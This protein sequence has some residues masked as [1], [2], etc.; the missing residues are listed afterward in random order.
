[1]PSSGYVAD[2]LKWPRQA[3]ANLYLFNKII[4]HNNRKAGKRQ[5]CGSTGAQEPLMSAAND[6]DETG[7]RNGPEEARRYLAAVLGKM[8]QPLVVLDG[9][10]RVEMANSAF[11]RTFGV[12]AS[13]TA[14]ARHQF[15]QVRGAVGARRPRQRDLEHRPESLRASKW[16]SFGRSTAAPLF[17]RRSGAASELSS[18]NAHSPTTC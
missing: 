5:G 16:S 13:E 6:Q 12:E 18:S 1:M 10:L 2:R 4:L 9:D 7:S 8:R 3:V 17:V 15:H 14:R 11:Y